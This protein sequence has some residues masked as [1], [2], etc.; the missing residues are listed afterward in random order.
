ML[1]NTYKFFLFFTV[2]YGLYLKLGHKGQNR[3]LLIASYIFY[4][5]WNWRFLSLILI[6]TI[7]DYYCGIQIER[8]LTKKRSKLFLIISICS[9]LGILGIFKYYDFFALS[10]QRLTNIFGW[11]IEP[12]F[13]NLIL[14][15][16][17][18]FYTFQT[19]S[20]TIDIYFKKLKPT[21]HFFDFA[22]YVAYFPQLVAGPI[23]RAKHLL[24]Q[25]LKPRIVTLDLFY[26]GAFLIFWGIFQK[27]FI[28]DNLAMIVDPVFN[29]SGPY[30]GILVLVALY[31]FA[32]Q[33]Y[34]DFAG[35]S[36][37]ARGLSKCMG[38]DIMVNFNLPYFAKN[39][40]DFW[41]RWHISL[42]TWL[43]DYLYI[44]LGGNKKGKLVTYRN[45]F[46]TMFL[47][48]VWHGAAMTFVVWGI[49]HG[50]LLIIYR[51]FKPFFEGF[52]RLSKFFTRSGWE[53]IK[54]VF[55]FHVVTIGWLFFRANSVGDALEMMHAIIFNFTWDSGLDIGF[56]LRYFVF[57]TWI[58]V[59]VQWFQY[60]RIDLMV[61][62]RAHPI[63][64]TAF[65]SLTALLLIV[66]GVIDGNEFIYFQF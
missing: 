39:P 51:L 38:F 47:G 23:E 30:N 14:P 56:N 18:S 64:R 62:Y 24:P 27:A 6:S 3:M 52:D 50:V 35:Y 13:L 49:Y 8:E 55:F 63:V 15:V 33:I 41:R 12:I 46:I 17:I 2:V 53:A 9:N 20:Y 19:M 43:R 60:K 7:I 57:F 34:C 45:L 32:F 25:V 54:I 65:Y 28:A 37:I 10:F 1:F 66:F 59:V 22:L 48:G 29:G 16:G 36:N 40:S 5:S 11:N 61:V 31:A 21:K 4:G 58:L 26:Q 42:S 44:P